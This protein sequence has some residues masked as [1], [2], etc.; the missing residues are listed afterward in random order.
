MLTE[1][2]TSLK[3]YKF[4]LVFFMA[5][6]LMG[7]VT[8]A[9]A[10]K[11]VALS[12]DNGFIISP[13]LWDSVALNTSLMFHTHIFNAS[14]GVSIYGAGKSCY[15]HIYNEFNSGNHVYENDTGAIIEGYD[16][17]FSIPST[18][19]TTKGAY[20][21]KVFCNDSSYGGFYEKPF[22]V[23]NS[24]HAPADSLLTTIIYL[25]FIISTIGLLGTFILT[26]AK[27]VT[28]KET[29]FGVLTTW[30]FV[31]LNIITNYLGREYL[32]RYFIE[33]M[34]SFLMTITIWSNGV[35]PLISLIITMFVLGTKKKRPLTVEEMTGGRRLY[36]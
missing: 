6:M 34:T 18:V 4:L 3:N 16:Y 36:G 35:L 25:L 22:Y 14:N 10:I 29:I 12:N 7:V 24:G 8:P 26:L 5:V 9:P 17:E 31:L 28:F 30:G 23:T 32:L 20:S 33:D 15:L 21:Y 27:L 19:L 11:S 1:Q 2:K 13:N